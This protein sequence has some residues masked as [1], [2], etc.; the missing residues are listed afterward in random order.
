[1]NNSKNY[2]IL[3]L[4]G[5]LILSLTTHPAQSASAP[6]YATKVELKLLATTLVQ[7]LAKKDKQIGQLWKCV[8]SLEVQLGG[9]GRDTYCP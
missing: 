1:M 2:I 8:N 6:T 7:E 5:L 4:S 3:I 9:S